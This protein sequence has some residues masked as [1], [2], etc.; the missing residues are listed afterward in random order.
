MCSKGSKWTI[1]S[2]S[3]LSFWHDKWMSDGMVGELVE[4]PLNRRE[5]SL[6]IKDVMVDGGWNLATLSFNFPN[7]VLRNILFTPLH[8]FSVNE[9]QKSWISSPNG[10]FNPKN[11]YLLAVGEDLKVLDFSGK[12]LWKLKT[13]P[14]NHIFLWKC[15]HQSACKK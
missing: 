3:S 15:L 2:N 6:T 14:K 13:L 10:G 12:W 11:A 9:D 7:S 8:R 5:D 4:G 1:G